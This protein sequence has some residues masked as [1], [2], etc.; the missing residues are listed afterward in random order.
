MPPRVQIIPHGMGKSA[1]DCARSNTGCEIAVTRSA[2]P[3]REQV[4]RWIGST[5]ASFT[6][7]ISAPTTLCS[8]E[9]TNHERD[10][11]WQQLR[12]D[13]IDPL[14]HA[15]KLGVVVLSFPHDFEP[16]VANEAYLRSLKDPT[17]L[18]Q[19]KA[20]VELRCSDWLASGRKAGTLKLLQELDVAL[21]VTD[22]VSTTPTVLVTKSDLLVIR[23]ARYDS[24]PPVQPDEA[25]AWRQRL[26]EEK[27]TGYG[28]AKGGVVC[29]VVKGNPDRDINTLRPLATPT[30]PSIKKFFGAA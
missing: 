8:N 19:N 1:A 20:A 29:I 16:S 21:V 23:V 10:A 4:A 12:R 9:L 13:V 24:Q 22:E 28:L 15:S 7:G 26:T 14:A 27:L 18:G 2:V 3:A 5:P 25:E 6:F 11:L 17:R 30:Q